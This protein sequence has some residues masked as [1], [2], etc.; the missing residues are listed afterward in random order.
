MKKQ[1]KSYFKEIKKNLPCVNSTMRKMLDDLKVSV[2]TFVA[3]NDISDF[4]AVVE[5]FGTAE[6]IAKEFAIGL[7]NSYVKSYKFKKRVIAIVVS[8]LAVI[9]VAVIALALY[10]FIENEIH[11][12]AL[13]ETTVKYEYSEDYKK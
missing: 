13:S 12:P 4:T 11:S 10:I 3:E 9:M 7:D 2:N 8:I 5:H 6:D 1:L